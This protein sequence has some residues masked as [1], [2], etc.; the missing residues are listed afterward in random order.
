M[1]KETAS[2]LDA[3]TRGLKGEE[4]G[5]VTVDLHEKVTELT[6]RIIAACAFGSG[7]A[8][9]PNAPAS[10]H[11][12]MRWI[13]EQTQWRAV[14]LVGVLPVIQHLPFWGK[15]EMDAKRAS[16]FALVDAVVHDRKVGKTGSTREG[17][18]DLLDLLISAHDPDTGA[19]FTDAE[20]RE[21]AMTLVLAGHETTS[22]LVSWALY[23][24]ISRPHL[25]AECL[26]QVEAVCGEEPPLPEHL[27]QLG[28]LDAV[29]YETLR[30]FPPVP[31]ISKD[32]VSAH[33]ISADDPS[34]S[35]PDLHVRAG[36]HIHV[37]FHVLHRLPEFW[38]PH[39]DDFDHTR[40]MQTKKK[41]YSHPYAYA[42]FSS[43][44]RNCIGQQFAMS[45]HNNPTAP[46]T[47]TAAA[48][49]CSVLIART[50]PSAALSV[51]WRPRSISTSFTRTALS[52]A[53]KPAT[54]PLTSWTC[55]VVWCWQVMLAMVLQRVCMEYVEGQ[56]VDKAGWPIHTSIITQSPKYPFLVRLRR[57]DTKAT[58]G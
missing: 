35:K 4:G 57:R 38:G 12:T 33:S 36:M 32:V 45:H 24:L 17:K 2:A 14:N 26:Q 37:D 18:Q 41:P 47:P 9:L 16:M 25:W 6:F 48:P 54:H 46:H 3:W 22:N 13:A 19:F 40:W 56:K 7:F 8:S 44:T 58:A 21:N 1:A 10:L 51:G 29:L 42:P 20:T 15:A 27:S 50:T 53:R 11:S 28:L 30:L 23:A 31:I 49:A 55:C 39:A 5:A 43:G 34:L 52:H